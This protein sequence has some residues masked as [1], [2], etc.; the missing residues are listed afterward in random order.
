ML[1]AGHAS[2]T[3]AVPDS[4]SCPASGAAPPRRCC[5]DPERPSPPSPCASCCGGC[6]WRS[7]AWRPTAGTVQPGR[8]K[9]P[10]R[11]GWV[12]RDAL[13][14]YTERSPD[15]LSSAKWDDRRCLNEKT[16]KR[17]SGVSWYL[18]HTRVV[19]TVRVHCLC[20]LL[21]TWWLVDGQVSEVAALDELHRHA[22]SCGVVGETHQQLGDAAVGQRLCGRGTVTLRHSR[23]TQL[24]VDTLR[25]HRGMNTV[26]STNRNYSF[27][28]CFPRVWRKDAKGVD[29]M[30][31]RFPPVSAHQLSKL[32]ILLRVIEG[33][34]P[35][36]AVIKQETGST[37]DR[38][39]GYRR[40]SSLMRWIKPG[41]KSAF[42][43]D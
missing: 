18:P 30:I 2:G 43:Y 38:P 17:V 10:C 9:S 40:F 14:S 41:H 15:R 12:G 33:L 21:Q 3:P 22:S 24:G 32:F 29:K 8:Q 25:K 42:W 19:Y 36:P 39:P 4:P 1:P 20:L 7:V 31:Y 13:T 35:I 37:L 16:E 34:E 23:Q 28:E 26:R 27:K 11:Q 6:I 5:S